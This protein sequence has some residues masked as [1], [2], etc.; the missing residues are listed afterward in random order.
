MIAGWAV[1][2]L[3]KSSNRVIAGCL[4][5][6]LASPGVLLC[7]QPAPSARHTATSTRHGRLTEQQRVLHALNRLTFGP[8]P[9][10]VARVTQMG[11]D[12]WLEQQLRPDEI[13][14]AALDARLSRF[15]AMRISQAE[16]VQRFPTP[17]MLRQYSTGALEAPADPMEQ[18]IYADAAF[19]YKEKRQVAKAASTTG[20]AEM[21][22]EPSAGI[23]GG[24]T[25][26]P[27][28]AGEGDAGRDTAAPIIRA[29]P[30]SPVDPAGVQALLALPAEQ[31]FQRIAAIS[32]EEMQAF[33]G[34]LRGPQQ[35]RLLEGMTPVEMEEVEAMQSPVRVV[36]AEAEATR[37]LRDVYSERQLQAVMADFW[38]NHF[39]VYLRKNQNEPYLLPAYERDVILPHALGRFEDLLVATAKS[40]AMLVYLDNWTSIGPRSRAAERLARVAQDRPG[41]PLAN[42]AAQMPKGI[43][44][45]YA[46]EL[47]ELHTL[48]VNGGYTQQDVIEV[49]RCFTG[50]T[51]DRPAQGGEFVFNPNRHEPGP[52]TVLG[53]V[54]P[55]GGEDEGL[56]VLH[57]LASSPAT[58]HL[59]SLQLAQ[60][61]V[62]DTPPE[63]LV[64]RMATAYLKSDGDIGTVLRTM[65]H[66][67]E[68]WSPAA[69]HAKVKTP[70]E[71]V[72]S[73][74]RATGAEVSNPVPLAQA[75]T[76][77][78]M[79]LYG[80]Q[81]P[82]G[83][84]W[85][86]DAWVSSNALLTRMNFALLLSANR[87]PGT[88][89]DWSAQTDPDDTGAAGPN[90]ATEARLETVLLGDQ[91]AP[92]TRAA[93][94]QAAQD[95]SVVDNAAQGF[96]RTPL[97]SVPRPM[98]PVRAGAN[99]T[100]APAASPGEMRMAALAGLLL[101]SPD[102]QRR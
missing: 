48:G 5:V 13:P 3:S 75:L 54:I 101:G 20:T 6:S 73:A 29:H 51:I 44:E 63:A 71:F 59:L 80:M 84:S 46:R 4:C 100:R 10:D 95:P 94:M 50:W 90:A 68:F 57:I 85:Q 72:T 28:A 16:L 43:N 87:L 33:R 32:P 45:N 40:P 81:T 78:G 66:S 21:R 9:G 77:L 98:Y 92:Q 79:P 69:F 12:A 88:R 8:R 37:L 62:S 83:Y 34:M 52:K 97:D 74:L 47:M 91:A 2:H 14:D 55:E 61:F 7:E 58:A 39:N 89:I 70:L 23:P 67:P 76:R 42:A 86:A 26:P 24:S 17:Q 36:G 35:Q 53:H 41:T 38:L 1:S 60:R 93:V 25:Q 11:L 19:E 82:N 22:P 96:R 30:G 31:R 102:F 64:Q 27:S 18:A 49:A 65:F 99:G 15:P 56:A